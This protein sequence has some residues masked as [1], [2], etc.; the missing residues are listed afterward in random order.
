M[1]RCLKPGGVIRVGG[2]N[3]DMAIKKFEEHDLDWF[4]DC[5]GRQSIGGRFAHFVLWG[6]EHL[7]I[8]TS[9]YLRE[10]AENAGFDQITFCKPVQESHFPSVFE[11][12]LNTEWEPT[13]DVPRT[14]M[15][16]AHKP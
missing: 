1:F 9:S 10:L 12:A 11:Q 5:S 2:P 4:G 8:L 13:P 7:G 3:G 6:G 14:L 16:E 15:M